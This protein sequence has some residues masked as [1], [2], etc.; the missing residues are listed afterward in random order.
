MSSS[1]PKN[2]QRREPHGF[3]NPSK[4]LVIPAAGLGSRLLPATDLIPKE[5]FPIAGVPSLQWILYEALSINVSKVVLIVSKN[6][7]LLRV[8]VKNLEKYGDICS[9]LNKPVLA[10]SFYAAA[11]LEFVLVDQDS[12]KGLGH[13]IYLAKNHVD[14]RF[15]VALPD[16]IFPSSS[17]FSDLYLASSAT[18]SSAIS[19]KPTDLKEISSYG[20]ADT[21]SF[22]QAPSWWGVSAET[23]V[24]SIRSLVEK[25]TASNAPSNLAVVGRYCLS[26]DVFEILS[27]LKPSKGGE[28]QL[29]DALSILARTDALWGAV[30]QDQRFDTGTL[31]GFVKGSSM[32][33]P[34]G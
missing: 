26:Q 31:E 22:L 4:T 32:T 1:L 15:L 19:L 9:N 11:R 12:P 2:N 30:G 3:D 5:L 7:P 8:F 29:T 14:G 13:A 16:E 34:W 33:P 20:V 17:P 6:K 27:D 25:P 18:S 21:A 10:E 24:C 23:R 28:I